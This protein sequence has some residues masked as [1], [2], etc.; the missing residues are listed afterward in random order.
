M[1]KNIEQYFEKCWHKSWNG[2]RYSTVEFL[3]SFGVPVKKYTTK[4][5]IKIT[6]E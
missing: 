1:I 5:Q 2:I 4:L 6:D 3:E